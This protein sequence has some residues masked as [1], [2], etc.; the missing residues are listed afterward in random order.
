MKKT[1]FSLLILSGILASVFA[2]QKTTERKQA[3]AGAGDNVAGYA[4]ADNIGW[5]SFNSITD[6]IGFYGVN[7]E[8]DGTLIGEAWSDHLGW[9]KF[10]PENTGPGGGGDNFSAR[11]M[12]DQI[13]GWARACTAFVSSDCT[14]PLRDNEW[15]GWI[16]FTNAY[17][18]NGKYFKGAAWGGLVIGWIDLSGVCVGTDCAPTG[19]TVDLFAKKAGDAGSGYSSSNIVL[20]EAEAAN[21]VD[22]KWVATGSQKT[23]EAVKK[24]VGNSTVLEVF[25][26]GD[27]NNGEKNDPDISPGITYKY[28]YACLNEQ[29]NPPVR[30]VREVLVTVLDDDGSTSFAC[31]ALPPNTTFGVKVTEYEWCPGDG[32]GGSTLVEVSTCANNNAN[33]CDYLKKI[34]CSDARY[35]LVNGECRLR[36]G[37][38]DFREF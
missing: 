28:S 3:S 16:K 21:G 38:S 4:W 37:D 9:I 14:G 23:C 15:D 6:G 29:D 17:L 11:V 13:R 10:A 34:R 26:T 20:T 33:R 36:T 35:A 2:W 27:V 5:I 24:Q 31:P 32:S 7:L 1:L 25:G 19:I 18:E 8:G 30:V 22:I 12:G